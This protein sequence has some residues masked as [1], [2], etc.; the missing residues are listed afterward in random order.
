VSG[1]EGR[2]SLVGNQPGRFVCQEGRQLV[3]AEVV[4]GPQKLEL[5]PTGE[6]IVEVTD[7]YTSITEVLSYNSSDFCLAFTDIPDYYD[8]YDYY[9]QDDDNDTSAVETNIRAI[10]SVCYKI[11]EEKGQVFTG[12]F[13]PTAIF[14][15]DFFILITIGVYLFVKDMR[16]NIFGKIT[17]GFLFNV[18]I[19]YTFL[20]IHYSMDLF[21]HKERLNTLFCKVLGYIIQHTFIGFFFWMSAMAFNITYTFSN[22][23]TVKRNDNQL[24]TLLLNICYAQGCPLVI[25][26]FTAA[27]DIY[28]PCDY[29]LPNMGK[30]TCFLGSEHNPEMSFFKTPEFLYFYLIIGIITATNLICFIITGTSL[31]SHWC[32][33]KELDSS[34]NNESM[35]SQ[36]GI[37]FKLFI[38]M[39]IP[40]IFDIV[41]AG[42]GHAYG[43]GKSFEVRLTLDIF[44]LLTGVFIFVALVCKLQVVK[45]IKSRLSSSGSMKTVLS[46]KSSNFSAVRMPSNASSRSSSSTLYSQNSNGF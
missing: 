40:W 11:E 37:V 36:F 16:K 14:I 20:G 19:C 15:S 21:S 31:I 42:V 5:S 12:L 25:T 34:V 30:F 32:Q 2:F 39:G 41:S 18:F 26:C 45:G 35:K 9:G 3:P 43:S 8:Y 24:K 10:Y 22:T 28:G 1:G 38:I 17:I 44:N 33:M 7:F 29:I 13:Y 46:S 23:F 6:L 27:M 4:F